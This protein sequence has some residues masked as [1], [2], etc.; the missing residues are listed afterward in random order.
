MSDEGFSKTN[1]GFLTKWLHFVKANGK[2]KRV[3]FLNP[4]FPVMINSDTTS[5]L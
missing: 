5:D 4:A 2:P 3:S 1:D